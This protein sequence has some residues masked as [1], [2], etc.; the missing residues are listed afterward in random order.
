MGFQADY[1]KLEDRMRRLAELEGNIFLPNI[2]PKEAAKY[3]LICMEPSL[4][5]WARSRKEA[6]EKIEAGFRNFISSIGDFILHYCVRNYLCHSLE[7]YHI[8]DLSKG[9]MKTKKADHER[10]KRYDKWYTLLMDEIALIASPNAHFFAV[11]KKVFD[12]LG[13]KRFPF[14]LTYIIHYS[15]Q[16]AKARN[17]AIKGREK[18]F[19]AFAET[20]ALNDIL[21]VARQFLKENSV[22]K[23]IFEL[24]ISDLAKKNLTVSR[25]KLIFSYKVAFESVLS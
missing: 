4:G 5:R 18:C 11:G 2:E 14:P 23:E 21:S 25:K 15:D 17:A 3:V 1:R 19:Q 12:Y 16:A 24:I 6:R 22:S 13:K 9:A 10:F 7:G 8:T 20:V